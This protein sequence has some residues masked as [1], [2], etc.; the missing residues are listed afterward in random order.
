MHLDSVR[1]QIGTNKIEL[2]AQN[3]SRTNSGAYTG[4]ISAEMLRDFGIKWVILGHSERR[5]YYHETDQVVA[6]KVEIAL[7]NGL[8][9]IACIGET[10]DERKANTTLNVCFRQLKAIAGEEFCFLF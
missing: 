8:N 9:V 2:S 1:K 7:K 5:Q 6:E 4:E 3:C 10:I